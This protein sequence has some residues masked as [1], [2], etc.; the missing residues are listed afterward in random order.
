MKKRDG[1]PFSRPRLRDLVV[2]LV[3]VRADDRI[4]EFFKTQDTQ[5]VNPP[6]EFIGTNGAYLYSG[7]AAHKRK[8]VS[9]QGHIPVLA[10]TRASWTRGRGLN[11][12]TDN[13]CFLCMHQDDTVSCGSGPLNADFVEALIFEEMEKK[14]RDFQILSR[15]RE[16]V[17]DLQT[18]RLR[19]RIK[20]IH[21]EFAGMLE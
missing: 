2:N 4:Y 7:E 3:Y 16:E 19:G 6:G 12:G 21:R 10:P 5:V 20:A 8:T 18:I 9:L 1:S 15:Q 13:R 17:F 11:A 14:L